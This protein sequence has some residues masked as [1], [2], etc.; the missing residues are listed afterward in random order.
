MKTITADELLFILG[1]VPGKTRVL[2]QDIAEGP[3]SIFNIRIE[4]VPELS[5]QIDDCEVVIEFNELLN[6][7]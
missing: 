4:Y 2:F 1:K 6:K 5:E 3:V 7:V